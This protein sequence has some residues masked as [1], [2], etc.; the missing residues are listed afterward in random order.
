MKK[1]ISVVL[2]VLS[3]MMIVPVVTISSSAAS[4]YQTYTYSID[5]TALYS[6]DAYSADIA[7]TYADMGLDKQLSSP[8]D[9][10]TDKEGNVYIAD[11]GNNRIVVLN[12]NYEYQGSI[13]SFEFEGNPQYFSKPQG[14]FVTTES[15]WVCDTA[16]KRLIEFEKEPTRD[17]E[18]SLTWG[19]KQKVDAPEDQ[20]FGDSSTFSPVAM[21]VDRYGR[22][23][24]VSDQTDEGIIVM[25]ANGMFVGFIGSQ[26]VT[27][28]AWEI[29]WRNFQTAEQRAKDED[30]ETTTYNNIT[31]TDD[32]FIYVTT[33]TIEASSV[34]G[35]IQ[36]KSKDGKYMPVKLLNPAGDE[37]MR[38]NGFWPPAG[39]IDIFGMVDPEARYSGVSQITDVAAG[40]EKTWSII[41]KNRRKI[42]TY[43][44]NGN[45]LFAFGDEGTMLGNVKNIG[46]ITYQGSKLLVLDIDKS[47]VIVYNR[48]QYGDMLIE[49]IAA[50]NSLNFDY[51]IEC[52]EKVLQRN[53]NF[54][55]AYVGIGNALYRSAKYEEAM[56]YYESAYDTENWSE[57]YKMVRKEWMSKWL[58]PLVIVLI[59]L[60]VLLIKFLGWAA[61][62]NKRVS[63]DGQV[64]K[65]FRHELLYGFYVIF[66][67]FDGFYDLKHERRGSV[68]ASLVFIGLAIVTVFYQSIGR[69]YVMN[70][71]GEVSTI[72]AQALTVLL[73]LMLF[74][75]AN[76]CLTT[77]FEGEGSFKD[78]FI[79]ASYSLLP[80]T[81]LIIPATIAS[82][83]VTTTEAAIVSMVNVIA[84]IWLGLLLF[85]GTMVTHDYSLGKNFITVLGTIVAMAFIVFLVL[86]FSML[87]T[88]M[89][90]LITDIVT[91]IQQRA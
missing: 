75:I 18:G 2:I 30:I 73:P 49:A 46:A 12:A 57:A 48:T 68:R 86:L 19:F 9:L 25:N 43:D 3:L 50:E 87:L 4:A 82:N 58:I 16:N 13:S 11:T 88:N 91:E 8:G 52:W 17:E 24:V 90:G 79:A 65:K 77:L 55:A 15:I 83:W 21:A 47:C 53:S 26:A 69:G 6:P 67:P 70:P 89:V 7:L 66:H 29:I 56:T 22:M 20:L 63:T 76:W 45:L 60:I 80:M 34:E 38:R 51:A 74:V 23:Y 31:I 85:F 42:Y 72:W 40:P 5:G 62:V 78:I 37:I 28:S 61:K 33:S 32:G 14:V 71:T 81:L 64:K 1:L 54:D 44:Y 39:E 41:D 10:V 36:S 84:Y 59:A 27:L 35:A